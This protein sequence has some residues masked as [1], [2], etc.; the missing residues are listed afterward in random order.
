MHRCCALLL[1]GISLSLPVQ[2]QS[3]TAGFQ[4]DDQDRRLSGVIIIDEQHPIAVIEQPGGDFVLVRVGDRLGADG[5]VEE[6]TAHW[7]RVRDAAGERLLWVTGLRSLVT[8]APLVRER[9]DEGIAYNRTLARQE[10]V[11]ELGKL[12]E[13][14]STP[15]LDIST[16]LGPMLDLPADA[17]IVEVNHEP[18]RS[19]RDGMTRIRDAL[20]AGSVV[21]LSIEGVYGKEG[22]YL[23][24]GPEAQP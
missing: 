6:I 16:L 1:L 19:A 22:V 8:D 3:P 2:A 23:M 11:R 21:R 10:T 15:G 7:L 4:P 12:V 13:T 17:R 20:A 14:A 5:R 24:P 18:I 9:D